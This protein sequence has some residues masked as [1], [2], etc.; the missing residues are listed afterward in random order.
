[1]QAPSASTCCSAAA[2]EPP[3]SD[4]LEASRCV[5]CEGAAEDWDDPDEEVIASVQVSSFGASSTALMLMLIDCTGSLVEDDDAT[6]II[7]PR[8][9]NVR[10]L[11]IVYSI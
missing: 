5:D 2:S 11:P 3:P 8:L 7:G 4:R 6:A 1:M 10:D 9:A